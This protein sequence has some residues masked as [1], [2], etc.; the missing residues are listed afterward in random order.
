MSS[1]SSDSLGCS[2]APP[3][4]LGLLLIGRQNIGGLG[5]HS[6]ERITAFRRRVAVAARPDGGVF[7]FGQPGFNAGIPRT[8]K[9]KSPNMRLRS[10]QAEP[11]CTAGLACFFVRHAVL[12]RVIE[13]GALIWLK[14]KRTSLLFPLVP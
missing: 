11:E 14:S 1:T 10:P 9:S 5:D 7:A 6:G 3:P 12:S 8:F 2:N 13:L 4:Q